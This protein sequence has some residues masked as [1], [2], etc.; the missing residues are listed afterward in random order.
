VFG[1]HMENFREIRDL[2][3]NAQ[4]AIEVHDARELANAVDRLLTDTERA[5]EI[6]ARARQVVEANS[7][8]TERV[9]AYLQ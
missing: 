7:G 4:A 1:P 2:F 8:A 6:G 5:A 3:I 9:L